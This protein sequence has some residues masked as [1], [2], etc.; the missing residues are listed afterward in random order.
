MIY[1]R[2][3]S[4]N[5]RGYAIAF[6]TLGVILGATGLDMTLKWPLAPIGTP[7]ANIIFGEPS[8]AFGVF[9][10]AAAFYFWRNEERLSALKGEKLQEDI[11]RTFGPMSLFVLGMGLALFAIAVAGE[12]FV[13]FAAPPQEPLS[14]Y[15]ADQPRIEASFISLLFALAGL[16]AV[17]FPSYLR[18]FS[19]GTTS[20]IRFSWWVSGLFFFLFS[21][22]NY[23][24]HIGLVLHTM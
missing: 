22:L 8:L 21:A 5:A 7:F 17:L 2:G 12:Y 9:L 13:L 20:V 24:T 19:A 23:F 15:F 4:P 3:K 16:G 1:K 10:L 11:A 18:H 14:G 6:A